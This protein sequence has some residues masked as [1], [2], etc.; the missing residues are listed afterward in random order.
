MRQYLLSD[1][2]YDNKETFKKV[3][4]LHC[5][6]DI[7]MFWEK[8]KPTK[9]PKCTSGLNCE[10]CIYYIIPL[11]SQIYKPSTRQR[12]NSIFTSYKNNLLKIFPF[13]NDNCYLKDSKTGDILNVE[14]RKFIKVAEPY[15]WQSYSRYIWIKYYG[16][17]IKGD[18]IH[19]ISKV[20]DYDSIDNL[21]AIPSKRHWEIHRKQKGIISLEEI[22]ELR[23][24][25]TLN[26]D[27]FA[28]PLAI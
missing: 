14:N 23:K 6:I 16:T 21:I 11:Q 12:S 28:L 22:A 9:P 5:K 4:K 19:H 2:L 27:I 15:I 26:K 25:Y 17:I 13:V 20:S 1:L 3:N 8:E 7:F 18:A 10:K 24:R